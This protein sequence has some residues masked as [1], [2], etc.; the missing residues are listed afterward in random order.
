MQVWGWSLAGVAVLA[1]LCIGLTAGPDLAERAD[2][3]KRE[4]QATEKAYNQNLEAARQPLPGLVQK[5]VEQKQKNAGLQQEKTAM[6][7]KTEES[8]KKLSAIEKQ[9]AA[10]K[11]KKDAAAAAAAVKAEADQLKERAAALQQEIAPLR[12]AVQTLAPRQVRDEDAGDNFN[13]IPP[14]Q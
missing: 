5:L 7:G 4:L 3:G 14:L 12:Q 10:V 9:V 2:I 6:A 11:V 1:C 13:P 8:R